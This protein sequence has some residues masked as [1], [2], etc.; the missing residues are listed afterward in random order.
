MASSIATHS[1]ACSRRDADVGEARIVA[2]GGVVERLHQIGPVAVG[3]QAEQP[4][5]LAVGGAVAVHQRVGDVVAVVGRLDA[6]EAQ[7]RVDVPADDV[8]AGAQQRGRD[9]LAD[10]GALPRDQRRAHR[11]DRGDGG[12]VIAHAAALLRRLLA[13]RRQRHADAGARPE[14]ADVVGRPVAIGSARA[15]AGE[16]AVDEAAVDRV[17]AGEIET[18]TRQR[19]H[20]Q[21]RDQHV[22]ALDQACR[23][24]AAFGVLEID[25]DAALAAIVEL[26]RRIDRHVDAG[27]VQEQSAHRIAG[28]RLELDHLGAPVGEDAGGRRSGHPE[29]QL[30]NSNAFKWTRHDRPLFS[31]RRR[32]DAEIPAPLRLCGEKSQILSHPLAGMRLAQ[33]PGWIKPP[34]SRRCR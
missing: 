22:G 18:D 9:E 10:A 19:A 23:D 15:V 21:V 4:E 8:D 5:P 12:R 7:A 26:E 30:E 16:V 17:D 33:K 13:L 6:A 29:A 2:Q 1:V 34:T 11:A 14:G 25:G 24:G 20:A 31:P 3:L 32:R 28:R 27:R